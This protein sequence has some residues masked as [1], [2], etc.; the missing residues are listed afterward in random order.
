MLA[1]IYFA[2]AACVGDFFCR[3]EAIFAVQ[4]HRVRAVE[5]EHR[6]TG[7]LV[8]AL[9]H[10]QVGILDVEGQAEAFALD[11]IGE[12]RRDIEVESVAEFVAP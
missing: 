10:L 9:M 4:N 8:F 3:R 12:G 5:H 1:L 2:L 6:C 11:G 7:R